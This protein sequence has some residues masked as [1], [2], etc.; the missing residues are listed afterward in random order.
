MVCLME[1][2]SKYKRASCLC[3]RLSFPN[4]L[5]V[6]PIGNAKLS[7]GFVVIWSNVVDVVSTINNDNIADIMINDHGRYIFVYEV[8]E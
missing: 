3:R 8:L 7:R 2:R 5:V 4:F 6:N 1:T